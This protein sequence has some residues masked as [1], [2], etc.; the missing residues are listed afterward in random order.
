VPALPRGKGGLGA[1]HRKRRLR[2]YR[3]RHLG[4][5]VHKCPLDPCGES[6]GGAIDGGRPVD[7]S[8][9]NTA[10]G[11]EPR[12]HLATRVDTPQRVRNRRQAHRDPFDPGAEPADSKEDALGQDCALS[13]GDIEPLGGHI[14]LQRPIDGIPAD[15]PF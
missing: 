13:V 11:P 5:P 12:P 2:T 10:P 6:G 15:A 4:P 1:A 8:H 3:R 14:D 7:G 9:H